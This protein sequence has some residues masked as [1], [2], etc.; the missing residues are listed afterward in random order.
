MTILKG[1][2]KQCN[3]CELKYY[4]YYGFMMLQATYKMP[5]Y[6]E[7]S[8]I[9]QGELGDV[10]LSFFNKR[11]TT[12]T[13]NAAIDICV[14]TIENL[15]CL[16]NSDYF[17]LQS[18]PRRVNSSEVIGFSAKLNPVCSSNNLELF[19]GSYACRFIIYE[20]EDQ[21]LSNLNS[22]LEYTDQKVLE[23]NF[24]DKFKN[25]YFFLN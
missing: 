2:F 12:I 6:I 20:C 24:L 19:K 17:I 11:N 7:L 9:K 14:H 13:M 18:L 15:S 3:D 10:K 8:S 1:F 23:S 16:N 21:E 25:I 22:C 5:L 4:P